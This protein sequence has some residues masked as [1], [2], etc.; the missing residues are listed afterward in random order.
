MAA[1]K[2]VHQKAER[3]DLELDRH[4]SVFVCKHVAAG[5]AVLQV[6]H[7][8]DDDWQFLCG[9]EHGDDEDADVFCIECLVAGDP[10]LNEVADLP[11]CH[12]ANREEVGAPWTRGDEA[13]DQIESDVAE[14]G[15]HAAMLEAGE[16]ESEPAFAYTVGVARTYSHPELICFGLGLEALHG[17]LRACVERIKAGN[18]PPIGAPF[19]GILDDS[20]VM[21]REVRAKSSYD[22]HLGYAIS[23]HGGRDFRVLQL[24]WP[25]KQGRFP[26]E[27]NADPAVATAQPLLA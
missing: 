1:K 18:P 9:I 4:A 15:W 8:F 5:A 26:G 27:P 11:D 23:F 14:F 17:M 10:S 13:E 12:Y 6:A 2:N 19:E 24:L 25:D 7:D 20:K 16:T 21:L 22:N 3:F